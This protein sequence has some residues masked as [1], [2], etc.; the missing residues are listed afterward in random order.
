MIIAVKKYEGMPVYRVITKVHGESDKVT[1]MIG[2]RYKVI[3]RI[4]TL[5]YKKRV[6]KV[7]IKTE[8]DT[9]FRHDILFTLRNKYSIDLQK[10]S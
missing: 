1:Y 4:S 5:I 10:T 8:V 6:K 7:Q 3:D 9:L 2:S